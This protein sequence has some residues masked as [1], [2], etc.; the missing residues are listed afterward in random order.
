MKP[1]FLFCLICLSASVRADND[2]TQTPAPKK[3]TVIFNSRQNYTHRSFDSIIYRNYT[4]DKKRDSIRVDFSIIH[5]IKFKDPHFN[6][7]S[8]H[9]S[10]DTISGDVDFMDSSGVKK[11]N[12]YF[13][14]DIEDC[15]L[16]SNFTILPISN[17]QKI[18]FNNCVFG[19]MVRRI[20]IKADTVRF[21]NCDFSTGNVT[22][23]ILPSHKNVCFELYRTDLS[24]I[25]FIYQKE[26]DLLFLRDTSYEI[27]KTV[28]EKLLS[29][30]KAE[31]KDV[32]FKN[33]DIKYEWW[34]A[35]NES[36][37]DYSWAILNRIWWNFGYSKGLVFLWT[38]FF[39]AI[40]TLF[41]LKNW[42]FVSKT[43]P[44]ETISQN[45]ETVAATGKTSK[46]YLLVML[47]TCLV[48]F[49]LNVDFKNLK[50]IKLRFAIAFIIQ[51]LIGL[52][53]LIFITNA[54][55]KF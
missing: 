35:C 40:F 30:F 41:N 10:Y 2:S 29:K 24:N 5:S 3:D 32:S 16:N 50:I 6:Y 52:T 39:L 20:Q 22:L 38:L 33:L 4:G 11:D 27:R 54:I 21:I 37:Y 18:V 47:Y 19:D 36:W 25:R 45:F 12:K 51:Y 44:I 55:L 8:Y 7:M 43:Y 49:S 23:E 42:A 34:K 17:V 13:F 28:F 9:L 48:F 15:F 26:I 14:L 53:C 31:G 1:F 46:K